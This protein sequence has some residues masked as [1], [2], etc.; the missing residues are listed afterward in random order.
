MGTKKVL[1]KVGQEGKYVV[2]MDKDIKIEDCKPNTRIALTSDSYV[3]HKI[4][5]SKVDPLVQLMKV[6]K[7][8]D[9]TYEMIGGVDKQIK[10]IKEVIELPIKHPEI[11][12]SL[13]ISQPKASSQV[14]VEPKIC[15][16]CCSTALRAP[17]RRYWHVPWPITRIAAPGLLS[18]IYSHILLLYIMDFTIF[19]VHT[20][21]NSCNHSL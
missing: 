21:C 14:L 10:E 19:Y 1:V 16:G 17:A 4:L 2:D 9:S 5:P 11:F 13:G 7:T 15:R 8:P 20:A 6:E 18:N 12:E 3:L